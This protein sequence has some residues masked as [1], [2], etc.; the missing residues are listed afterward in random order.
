[1]KKRQVG[2]SLIE[3]LV[4]L[5]IIAFATNLVVYSVSD[6]D[7]ELLEKQALRVHTLINL[8]SDF[9]VLNQVELGFHLE[10]NKL[11]FLAFDGNKWTP[12]EQVSE[13]DIFKS[14]EFEPVL[15]AELSLDDLPWAQDNLLEQIDW[16]E[17]MNSDSEEDF[18]E[19]DKMK[20]PQVIILSSGEVSAFSFSLSIKDK[21][22]PLYLIEGEFMAPVAMHREPLE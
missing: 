1:M 4:V 16:R 6:G 7:E 3:I 19:L 21:A 11:E 10:K 20:V 2:F 5:V 15:V 9:A 8:A 12:F 22:E 13:Q 18:L 14:F 17:L